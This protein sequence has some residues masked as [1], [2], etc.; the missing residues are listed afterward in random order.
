MHD[1]L[2]DSFTRSRRFKNKINQ[3]QDFARFR[4]TVEVFKVA[5]LDAPSPRWRN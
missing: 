4:N 1:Y 2:F 3:V 5:L